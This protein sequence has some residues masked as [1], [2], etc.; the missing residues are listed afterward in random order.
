CM[1]SDL[2]NQVRIDG[3]RLAKIMLT[4]DEW[5]LI[6]A[7]FEVLEDFQEL[8]ITLSGA[9]YPTLNL[10]YPHVKAIFENWKFWMS[11]II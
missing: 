5:K 9:K 6:E 2:N 7:I 1:Q 11:W 4:M 10:V 8:T 3:K